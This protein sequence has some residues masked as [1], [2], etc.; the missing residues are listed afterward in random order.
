M[1]CF[2]DSG[3]YNITNLVILDRD[4]KYKKVHLLTN[5]LQCDDE[6]VDPEML[7]LQQTKSVSTCQFSFE[8]PTKNDKALWGQALYTITSPNLTIQDSIGDFL[9]SPYC[10]LWWF[11]SEDTLEIYHER[12]D[13]YYEIYKLPTGVVVTWKTQ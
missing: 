2:I 8:K 9:C 12:L 4:R 7:L 13:G 1:E 6:I 3:A 11:C 5:I 10:Q